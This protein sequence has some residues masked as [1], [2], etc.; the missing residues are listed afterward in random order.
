M[1]NSSVNQKLKAIT[2]SRSKLSVL[3]AK[4]RS[5]SSKKPI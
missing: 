2:I 1:T 3:L 4:V 5:E